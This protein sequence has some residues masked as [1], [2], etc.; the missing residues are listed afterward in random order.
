MQ[1]RAQPRGPSDP[2][3]SSAGRQ[4]ARC[5][6]KKAERVPA[7]SSSKAFANTVKGAAL[8]AV[9][10]CPREGIMSDNSNKLHSAG[11]RMPQGFKTDWHKSIAGEIVICMARARGSAIHVRSC[12]GIDTGDMCL[13]FAGA[14]AEEGTEVPAGLWVVE[15]AGAAAPVDTLGAAGV[16]T[17]AKNLTT[18]IV[19]VPSLNEVCEFGTGQPM[20]H[21]VLFAPLLW[22]CGFILCSGAYMHVG[23][24]AQ[25]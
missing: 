17:A 25:Q 16:A 10:R 7:I 4:K 13:D 24:P 18:R 14:R 6:G 11:A 23:L 15:G 3:T 2:P 8:N 19:I 20:G 12:K 22:R 1:I 9:S 21:I 5:G